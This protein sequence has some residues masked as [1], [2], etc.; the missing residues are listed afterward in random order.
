M[1]E[2]GEWVEVTSESRDW[3]D[4]KDPRQVVEVET[5]SGKGYIAADTNMLGGGCDC[6]EVWAWS[7]VIR[8][9][10]RVV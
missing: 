4:L 8:Y 10:V 9:R 1:S 7:G 5:R 6:C 3:Q 2:W